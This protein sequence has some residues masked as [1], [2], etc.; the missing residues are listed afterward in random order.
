MKMVEKV[1]QTPEEIFAHVRAPF[2]W[3]WMEEPPAM[4]ATSPEAS[5]KADTKGTQETVLAH[6]GKLLRVYKGCN[7]RALGEN[8]DASDGG[9]Y[10][11]KG[12][13]AFT[14]SIFQEPFSESMDAM[15]V[16]LALDG[17][18]LYVFPDEVDAA[19]TLIDRFRI[20][21]SAEHWGAPDVERF[22]R[23]FLKG[24][25]SVSL[26]GVVLKMVLRARPGHLGNFARLLPCCARKHFRQTPVELLPMSL[27]TTTAEEEALMKRMTHLFTKSEVSPEEKEVLLQEAKVCGES[28]WLWIQVLQLNYLF[29]GGARP[30]GRV[31]PHPE[32]HTRE[33]LRALERLKRLVRLWVHDATDEVE[34]KSW[35][36]QSQ[37]LGDM[38]T[39]QEVRKAYRLTWESIGPHVPKAGEAARVKLADTVDD[40]LKPYVLDPSLVRIPDDELRE[41]P[42]DAP[43]LVESD[44]EYDL[45]VSNLVKAGMMER[46]VPSETLTVL[47]KPVL[48]GLFGVHKA[49]V[50]SGN[51]QLKRTLRLIVN[52]IPSNSVQRRLPVRPSERMSWAPLWGQLCILQ[53]EVVLAYG[54]DIKHC[55]HIFAPGDQWKGFFVISKEA[56]GS[57]FNDGLSARGRPRICSAPM[58]WSNIVDFVQSYWRKWARWPASR[59]RK[60]CAWENLHRCWS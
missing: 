2:K 29:C 42:A 15:K 35:E 56:S 32:T 9:V 16:S 25:V 40:V 5:G 57:C 6:R 59:Q 17:R 44:R 27:P 43:V 58:G 4:P 53:N 8:W 19:Q 12:H 21:G 11:G 23:H 60:L 51:G 24:K 52:L 18:P 55:F 41:P 26:C 54:E 39:G 46:E 36:L 10:V 30:L 50:S 14:C 13:G 7:I 20:R 49:W 28:A 34:I 47:G 38:Y 3:L 45:I 33:Q 48:N 22:V 1:Y 37:D 31:M